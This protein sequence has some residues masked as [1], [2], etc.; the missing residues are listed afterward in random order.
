M[1]H[2]SFQMCERKN[3]RVARVKQFPEVEILRGGKL[4]SHGQRVT[5]ESSQS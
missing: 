4:K 3:S 5:I 2:E 1:R